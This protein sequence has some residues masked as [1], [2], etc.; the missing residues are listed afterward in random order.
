MNTEKSLPSMVYLLEKLVNTESPSQ[1][2]SAVNK[3]GKII[4]EEVKSLGANIEII[5]NETTGD[6]IIAIF[7]EK[8]EIKKNEDKGFLLLCHMDTVFPVGTIDSM[9]FY[10]KDG[11]IMGPGVADMKS[12]AVIGLT[13]IRNM[14]EEGLMPTVPITILFTSDEEIGS[15]TSKGLIKELAWKS[16]LVL[17]LEPGLPDGS[18]K[19][20]RKGVGSFHIEVHG[21]AAHSG[22][23]HENGRNAIEELAHQVIRVQNLTDYDLGTTLNVGVFKGGTVVN[24]V[25]DLAWM[26]VDLRVMIPGEAERIAKQINQLKPVLQGTSIKISGGLNRPPMPY[27]DLMR[28]TFN[29]AKRIADGINI[30]LIASGT[31]GASDGNFIAPLGIPVLDGMGAIGGDYHSEYEYIIE[32]SLISRTQLLS[33]ILQNW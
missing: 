11:R 18:I 25:P 26:D 27:D 7:N 30:P 3:V 2:K 21:R 24:V 15:R 13:A 28:S 4:T 8:K 33:A 1:D 16:R 22:G 20:W 5:Q 29:K 6:H 14:I 19:T 12:G 17:V 10:M 9:P 32:E 23:K 31:G